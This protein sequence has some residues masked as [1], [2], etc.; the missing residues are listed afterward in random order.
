M[1]SCPRHELAF[2]RDEAASNVDPLEGALIAKEEELREH[3]L[4]DVVLEDV[5]GPR[6]ALSWV[7]RRPH[8]DDVAVDDDGTARTSELL[9]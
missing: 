2:P 9:C 7:A 5:D 4:N 1:I 8:V 3:V 6:A